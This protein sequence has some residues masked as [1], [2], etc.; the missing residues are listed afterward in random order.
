MRNPGMDV[1]FEDRKARWFERNPKKALAALS[2]IGLLG[3]VVLLEALPLFLYPNLRVHGSGK[4]L[5]EGG[6]VTGEHFAL[7]KNATGTSYGVEAVTDEY[8]FRIDP[9]FAYGEMRAQPAVVLLG[10]SVVFGTGVNA[11]DTF[12][13]LLNRSL[14][15]S[16]ESFSGSVSTTLPVSASL[17]HL[18]KRETKIRRRKRNP[19]FLI[20]RALT[21][22]S[23]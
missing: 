2:L 21:R 10:D 9:E 4:S 22:S 18:L 15:E 8:G 14:S 20:S 12:A 11:N 13:G 17:P 1:E 19:W 5:C 23:T 7:A 16:S 3:S 6:T